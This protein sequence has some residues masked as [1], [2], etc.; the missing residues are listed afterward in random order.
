MIGS[1][2]DLMTPM[3]NEYDK[4][5]YENEIIGTALPNHQSHQFGT[6]PLRDLPQVLPTITGGL[7]APPQ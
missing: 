3:Q 6:V 2:S 5:D 1:R 4:L 7:T